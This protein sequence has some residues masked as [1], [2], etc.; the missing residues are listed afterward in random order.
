MRCMQLALELHYSPWF[1]H[2]PAVN[3]PASQQ[4]SE[5]RCQCRAQ[6]T[7]NRVYHSRL[8]GAKRHDARPQLY[9]THIAGWQ[10][11]AP[12]SLASPRLVYTAMGGP[13]IA[14][15]YVQKIDA[16]ILRSIAQQPSPRGPPRISQTAGKFR[17][18]GSKD[19]HIMGRIN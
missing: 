2:A 9:V 16:T 14:T 15:S 19:S 18:N 4:S 10:A 6:R 11:I 1:K 8:A 13:G 7:A 5:H 17:T 12:T 3:L